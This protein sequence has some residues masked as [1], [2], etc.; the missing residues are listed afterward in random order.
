MLDKDVDSVYYNV[1]RRDKS[2]ANNVRITFIVAQLNNFIQDQGDAVVELAK[3]EGV[4]AAL[5]DKNL[6]ESAESLSFP[7]TWIRVYTCLES[8]SLL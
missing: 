4:V 6:F 1:H 8:T 2:S 7:S 5:L 3:S